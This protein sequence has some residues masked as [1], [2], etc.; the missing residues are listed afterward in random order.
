[1]VMQLPMKRLAQRR[2]LFHSEADFQ[3]ALAWEIQTCHSQAQVRLEFP[4][5]ELPGWHLDILVR[6]GQEVYPL[7][8]KYKTLGAFLKVEEE[9]FSLRSHGAQDIGKYDCLLD[10]QRME[11]M[12]QRLPGYRKG[13]AIWLSN[14]PTYWSPPSRAGTM[15]QAFTLHEGAVKTGEM[16]WAP[17]TGK[18]TMRSREAPIVLNG[19]YPIHW[20]DYS[21]VA[22][23]R[24]GLLRFALCEV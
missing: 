1:M 11:A 24:G 3:F 23:E 7:E 8:L 18:G 2:K 20:Q 9:L 12:K 16:A 6:L 5:P 17:H 14:D 19:R 4:P 22:H 21:R 13:F 15:A 10:L